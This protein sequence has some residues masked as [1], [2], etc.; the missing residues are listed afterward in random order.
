MAHRLFEDRRIRRHTRDAVFPGQPAQ[1][2]R[3][4]HAAGDVVYPDALALAQKCF[5]REVGCG[6]DRGDL[7]DAAAVPLL[8][9]KLRAKKTA[10][11]L[12]CQL[13]AGHALA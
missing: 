9:G 11:D 2:T 12:E 3:G 5:D 1:L 8:I 4:E 13:R 7:A 10:R 6:F